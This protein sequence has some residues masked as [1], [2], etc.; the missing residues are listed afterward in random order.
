M[1][2][3]PK[4]YGICKQLASTPAPNGPRAQALLLLAA[5][6]SQQQASE[7]TGLSPGQVRYALRRWR[8][9]GPS[10]FV[11]IRAQQGLGRSAD[12]VKQSLPALRALIQSK[13]G[14]MSKRRAPPESLQARMA[15]L[16]GEPND[17]LRRSHAQ[18]DSSSDD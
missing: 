12:E 13:G 1:R 5:G 3:R 14:S 2:L 6:H 4:E 16:P 15:K 11:H 8:A 17:R 18:D 9:M 10:M 7:K